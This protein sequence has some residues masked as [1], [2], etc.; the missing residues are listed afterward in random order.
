MLVTVE[1][2]ITDEPLET[3]SELEP[4]T[5]EKSGIDTTL[6]ERVTERDKLPLVPV[7][8]TV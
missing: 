4:A 1:V 7:T 8:K 3:V 6:T 5:S 2:E